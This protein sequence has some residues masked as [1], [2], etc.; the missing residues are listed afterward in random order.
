MRRQM[1]DPDSHKAFEPSSEFFKRFSE[2]YIY[3]GL[4][5]C[6][7]VQ[8]QLR[9]IQQLRQKEGEKEKTTFSGTQYL[10]QTIKRNSKDDISRLKLSEIIDLV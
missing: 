4:K 2:L 5:E 10:Q 7:T 8:N 6:N 9:Q 3:K 1:L